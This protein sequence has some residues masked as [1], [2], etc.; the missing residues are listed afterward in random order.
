M[1]EN[2]NIY[3]RAAL[4][5][6]HEAYRV[7]EVPIGAVVVRRGEIIGRGH[8]RRETWK[9]PTAHA[10]LLAIRD[11][12]QRLGGWRLTESV[13]YV[14]IEPC[15]MCAG[16]IVLARIPRLV[17]GALDPKGGAVDSLFDLVRRE[18]LNHRVEVTGGVLEDE[19]RALMQRFFQELR[20]QV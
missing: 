15:S 9:D 7:G 17:Y 1:A 2:D 12:C 13:L 3:M 8:N 11:A 4:D 16:A 14:T 5:E 18:D 6:A 20:G 10:E 19:C